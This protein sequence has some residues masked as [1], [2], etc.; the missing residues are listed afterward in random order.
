MYGNSAADHADGR[1]TSASSHSG[2]IELSLVEIYAQGL[3]EII[4]E[5]PADL[6]GLAGP[7]LCQ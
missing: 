5:T 4:R 1:D 3:G 6:T 7:F 2:P